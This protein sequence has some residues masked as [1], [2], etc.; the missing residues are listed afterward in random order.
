LS[1]PPLRRRIPLL[2]MSHPDVFRIDGAGLRLVPHAA[3]EGSA[4]REDREPPTL[5]VRD[6]DAAGAA[7]VADALQPMLQ[8]VEIN[9]VRLV[10]VERDCVAPT[11]GGEDLSSPGS[12]V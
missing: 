8:A 1:N 3:D 7:G 9:E 5:D 6:Q 2:A 4:V 10:R 11:Q 12:D